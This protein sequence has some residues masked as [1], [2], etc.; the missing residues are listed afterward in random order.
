MKRLEIAET[1]NTP[2]I[3][4]DADASV[5]KVEGKSFPEDSKEFYRPVI[6]WMDEYIASGPSEFSLRFNLFYLSSSSIIS[7]KQLLLKAVELQNKGAKVEVIWNYDEDDDEIKKTGEDYQKLTKMNF[8]FKVNEYAHFY[9]KRMALRSICGGLFFGPNNFVENGTIITLFQLLL[10]L[11]KTDITMNCIIVDDDEMSRNAMK[12][13]VG[14]VQFMNLDGIYCNATEA[15][16]SLNSK[17]TDLMLL[18]IEMPDMSGIHLIKSLRKPPL[19]ILVSSKKEYAIEAFECNVIDYLVKPLSLDRFFQACTKAKEYFDY[20]NSVDF[21]GKSFVFIKNDGI[22]TKINIREILWIEALGDYIVINTPERKY[23]VHS[24]M[25]AIESKLDPQKFI[26]IHRS[27]IISID[28]ITSIDDSVISINKQLI[29]IGA[30]YKEN[31]TK[32]LNLL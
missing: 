28:N 32:R 20:Q 17:K 16:N 1:N 12:H 9:Q 11:T 25:K 27:F 21:T 4:L 10:M 15:L 24:T 26:R 5:F 29:S 7:V 31:L 6:E 14:R 23:T 19:T 8:G 18:D 30:V 22:L 3:V 13:L 2:H